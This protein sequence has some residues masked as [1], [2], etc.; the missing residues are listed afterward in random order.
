M[1]VQAI[2]PA[3]GSGKRLKSKIPKP[4]VL[5]RG[6]PLL[7]Y[8]LQVLERCSLIESVVVVGNKNHLGRIRNFISKYR[9]KKIKHVIGGGATRCQ[10]VFKGLKVLDQDTEYVLIHDG[11]RP[12]VSLAVVKRAI[13]ACFKYAAVIVAVPV[14]ATIKRVTKNHEIEETPDRRTLWEAQTPQVFKKDIIMKAQKSLRDA[15]ATDDAY[16]VERMGIHVKVI[17]GDYQNIKITT[18]DDLNVA[19]KFLD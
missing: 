8:S 3:A 14:K 2:I 7:M 9:L 4:L 6:K 17:A 12:L 15:K 11:A 19:N 10:S 16:L 13:L 1:K 5:L 18:Q